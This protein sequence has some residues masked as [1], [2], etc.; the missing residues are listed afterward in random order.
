LRRSSLPNF[1]ACSPAPTTCEGIE[2][3][4]AFT[5]LD[6]LPNQQTDHSI[7]KTSGLNF[8][9]QQISLASKTHILN[10][11]AGMGSTTSRTLKSSKI[12]VANNIGKGVCHQIL[13]K[14]YFVTVP[15]PWT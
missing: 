10:S 8:G 9:D 4:G 3:K 6:K 13:V 5:N 12:M 14:S 11:C 2:G 15:T 1:I 7:K